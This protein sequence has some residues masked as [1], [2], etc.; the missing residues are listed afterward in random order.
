M[1][2]NQLQKSSSKLYSPIMSVRSGE[3]FFKKKAYSSIQSSEQID[4]ESQTNYSSVIAN[5]NTESITLSKRKEHL[6]QIPIFTYD[7]YVHELVQSYIPEENTSCPD[8]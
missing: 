1:K 2:G 4:Y 5:R 7:D 3:E 6:P 8:I